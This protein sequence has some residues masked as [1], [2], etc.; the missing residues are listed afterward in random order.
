M[1]RARAQHRP[2]RAGK[3]ERMQGPETVQQMLAV[4]ELGR[5]TKGIA[6]ALGVARNTVKRYLAAGGCAHYRTP[7]RPRK[8]AGLDGWLQAQ[9]L[10]HRGN[11]D[12][13]RQGLARVHGKCVSLRTV[14]RACRAHRA[15]LAARAR[16]TV[17]FETPPSK[18]MQIDFDV[19]SVEIGGQKTAVHLFVATLGHSRLGDVAAFSHQ[20]RADWFAGM[21]GAFAHYGDI[22]REVLMDNARPLVGSHN[23][24]SREVV[25][26]ARLHAFAR[27][28]GFTTKACAPYRPRTK[29]KDENGVGYVKNNALA[30]RSFASWAALEAHLAQWQRAVADARRHGTTGDPP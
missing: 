1:K 26:N 13:V 16:A 12:V 14:E 3:G 4:H 25:F 2:L 5:G 6:K 15:V 21:E 8:L 18:Q 24:Q 28:W 9:F 20:R 30:G 10:R 11:C 29:G 19:A 7:R 23:V 17:P 27:H 22:P